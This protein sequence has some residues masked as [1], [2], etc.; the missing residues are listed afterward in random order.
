MYTV[1]FTEFAPLWTLPE[2]AIFHRIELGFFSCA[3]WILIKWGVELFLK[4]TQIYPTSQCPGIG[5]GFFRGHF[6]LL[7]GPFSYFYKWPKQQLG[8]PL[9]FDSQWLKAVLRATKAACHGDHSHNR[10]GTRAL[11]REG[12]TRLLAHRALAVKWREWTEKVI[13]PSFSGP[14]WPI[15]HWSFW[16]GPMHLYS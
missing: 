11:E 13:F 2:S 10:A 1:R 8:R 6:D 16:A 5:E 4:K 7:F 9:V 3:L 12:L 14:L 15:F